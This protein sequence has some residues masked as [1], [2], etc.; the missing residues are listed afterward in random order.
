MTLLARDLVQAVLRLS[1]EEKL[2]LLAEVVTRVVV[3]EAPLHELNADDAKAFW[4]HPR[5]DSGMHAEYCAQVTIQDFESV[6]LY[7]GLSGGGTAIKIP[8]ADAVEF[9]RKAL[10][11]SRLS[12]MMSTPACERGS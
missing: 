3:K 2:Q 4:Q 10:N 5:A 11:V 8:N 6:L 9:F 12:L 7:M 1:D